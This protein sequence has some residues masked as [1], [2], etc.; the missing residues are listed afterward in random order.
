[1][2]E[3]SLTCDSPKAGREGIAVPST[4]IVAEVPRTL[5]QKMNALVV[6]R[7]KLPFDSHV[8]TVENKE[9]SKEDQQQQLQPN[10]NPQNAAKL[11]DFSP[12][13]PAACRAP[14]HSDSMQL[15]VVDLAFLQRQLSV[16]KLNQLHNNL[17]LISE[18]MAPRPLHRQKLLGR[19]IMVTEEVEMHLVYYSNIILIKPM[20]R[21]LLD[22]QFWQ[23]HI[24]CPS[25]GH[26]CS[27][28]ECGAKRTLYGWALGFMISYVGL[29]ASESDFHIAQQSHLLPEQ[30]GWSLWIRLVKQLLTDDNCKN[31]NKRYH[32]GELPLLGLNL[33]CYA[34]GNVGGYRYGAHDYS[35]FLRRNVENLFALFAFF[36]IIL[37]AMQVGLA[38]QMLAHSPAFQKASWGFTVASIMIP[39]VGVVF[40]LIGELI[41]KFYRTGKRRR[42]W[43]TKAS[44]LASLA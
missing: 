7:L 15:P 38:T 36:A 33:L 8:F 10:Q 37:T 2:G 30:V 31:I 18:P 1:V 12:L 3:F 6:T 14:D 35:N 5:E 25:E 23:D 13:L 32:Y 42:L 29:V 9:P 40:V 34:R 16:D 24:L 21:F 17:Y 26:A 44:G 41:I 20:P 28:R 4:L 43:I 19:G 11:V 39:L 27:R 22:A